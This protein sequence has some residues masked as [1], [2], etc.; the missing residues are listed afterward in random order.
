MIEATTRIA[1]IEQELQSLE[2]LRKKLRAEMPMLHREGT[3]QDLPLAESV[4]QSSEEKVSLFLSLFGTRR[5]VYP[6]L[7]SNPKSGH[8]G[9]SPACRNE[10]VRGI[11]EKPR[12][13][14]S[15]CLHQNFPP[16]DRKAVYSHLTG[17]QTIGTYAINE[18]NTCCFVAADFDGEGWGEDITAYRRSAEELG[19]EIA[20]ERSRSGN[21][22][23]A[24]LFFAQPVQAVV[25]RRLGTLVMAR[26]ASRNAR[27]NLSTYDRF[28]PNQDTLPKGGF[29]N[30]IALPLQAEPRRSENTVFLDSELQPLPDQWAY[31]AG[32]KKAAIADVQRIIESITGDLSAAEEVREEPYSLLFDE[33]ALDSIPKAV[34]RGIFTGNLVVEKRAQLSLQM[35]GVPSSLRAAL[36]RLGT[37]ANPNFY[38]KQRLRFPTF[39]IPRFIFCGKDHTDRLILPRGTLPEVEKLV[40]KAGGHVAVNDLLPNATPIHLHFHGVLTAEQERAVEVMMNHDN[41]ILVAPPGAGKT[42]MACAAI[43]R[44]GIPALVL[45]HRKPLKDQWSTRLQQFLGLSKKDIHILGRG[46]Y[47]DAFVA[48]GMFQT[49]AK[50]DS[51]A[52]L[53]KKYGQVV[54]DECHHVP[55]ASFEAAIKQ[56]AARYLLGL[57]ATPFRKDGLQKILYLQCG[58]IRHKIADVHASNIPR[59]VIV[60]EISESFPTD[61]GHQP[62]HELWELLTE[63]EER[64]RLI[65]SDIV[66]AYRGRRYLAVLSDRKEHLKRLELIVREILPEDAIHRMD[67]FTGRKQRM[68]LIQKLTEKAASETP[69]VLFA[70]ASLIGEG[71]DLPCL[72]TMVLAM[73]LSFKGRL[74]QYAGRLHRAADGKGDIRIHDYVETNHPM[75]MHMYRRRKVAYREMGY[76]VRELGGAIIIPA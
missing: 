57:T 67:G 45:V 76:A 9:Y 26:A 65:A 64:N 16:L 66:A 20:V 43:A 63:S 30:L 3:P 47:R 37:I 41:G 59:R 46:R 58:P 74:T 54:I 18:D 28:F 13:K 75:M 50:A 15:E 34:T 32:V 8:K 33:C 2:S 19:F 73:P 53:M 51:P 10:W 71:F 31:L 48:I 23:H 40:L 56:C 44:R 5:S 69:F 38:E 17:Q 35:E 1:Q 60:R 27:L 55:A 21:G 12:V 29:G 72:D 6:R 14:C 68:I 39:N 22:G 36:K 4:P 11:C 7:W 52:Q 24:W 25:A 61:T 62:I 70:T 42:V 49:L